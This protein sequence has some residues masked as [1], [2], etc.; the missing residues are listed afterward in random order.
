VIDVAVFGVDVVE[1]RPAA[2]EQRA[3]LSGGRLLAFRVNAPPV[4]VSGRGVEQHHRGRDSGA[5]PD[6]DQQPAVLC[7]GQERDRELERDRHDSPQ[8]GTPTSA[9]GATLAGDP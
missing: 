2:V 1:Q 8:A 9:C 6:T 3:K 7:V 5:E 4:D